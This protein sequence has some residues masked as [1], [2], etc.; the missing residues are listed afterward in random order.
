[1]IFVKTSISIR[2]HI[3]YIVLGLLV[4]I[5]PSCDVKDTD[6][7]WTQY[8]A[9]GVVVDS[10]NNQPI[11]SAKILC[12]SKSSLMLGDSTYSDSVGTYKLLVAAG[13]GKG[14]LVI[15]EKPGYL[16]QQ[17]DY[18]VTGDGWCVINF[19]LTPLR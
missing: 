8:I 18:I 17:K 13:S 12:L 2:W 16:S 11:D 5:T 19:N 15:A 9:T 3:M 4:C 14:F 10:L 6:K 7:N 1:M